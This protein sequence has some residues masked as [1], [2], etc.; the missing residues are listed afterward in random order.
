IGQEPDQLRPE[1]GGANATFQRI[2]GQNIRN[3]GSI[4]LLHQFA[5]KF[6][7]EVGYANSL[8]DYEDDTYQ[9]LYAPG[10]SPPGVYPAFVIPTSNSG[11]LDRTEHHAHIDARWTVQPATVAL[12]GYAYAQD[13]YTAKQPIGVINLS[14]PA[15]IA[16]NQVIYSDSRD[17]RTHYIYAG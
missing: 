7:V 12:V 11:L 2:P 5:P 3:Y 16:A 10:G 13:H 6:G 1:A 9:V 8:F 4:I 14:N 15:N 17:A